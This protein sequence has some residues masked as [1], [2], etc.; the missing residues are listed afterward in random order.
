MKVC[1]ITPQ[2]TNGTSLVDSKL[3]DA[4]KGSLNLQGV[5]L[6]DKTKQ[7]YTAYKA[8]EFTHIFGEHSLYRRIVGGMA[9]QQEMARFGTVYNN[10]LESLK[11]S[12]TLD[13]DVNGEPLMLSSKGNPMYNTSDK[14]LLNGNRIISFDDIQDI[15]DMASRLNTTKDILID[16]ILSNNN[17]YFL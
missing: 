9:N 14:S 1:S 5:E 10:D 11:K 12:I 3:F 2:V 15:E 4:I 16:N 7:V 8:D 17:I 6:R 13:L